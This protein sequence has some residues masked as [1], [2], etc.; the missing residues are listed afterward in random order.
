MF[1]GFV[2]LFLLLLG[3]A[4]L[5]FTNVFEDAI[6]DESGGDGTL[7]VDLLKDSERFRHLIRIGSIFSGLHS[8][9]AVDHQRD[10]LGCDQRVV[11]FV[12]GSD[13][14]FVRILFLPQ[15]PPLFCPLKR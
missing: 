12:R 15:S 14:H 6:D 5:E 4:L 10:V 8:S 13:H 9:R 2:D 1:G 3:V 11:N 7:A